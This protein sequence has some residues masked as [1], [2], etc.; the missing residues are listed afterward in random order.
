MEEWRPVSGYE[1]LYEVSS[2]GRVR[3]LPRVWE[4]VSKH[5]TLHKHTSSGRT[6]KPG[7][8]RQGYPSVV[9]GR[10]RTRLVHR[11][12]AEAFLGPCPAGK[13]VRH[14]DGTRTNN[15]ISN[16]AYG[17]RSE[18][19]ADAKLHGTF[20]KGRL[21][22]CKILPSQHEHIRSIYARGGHTYASIGVFFG[23][24]SGAILKI[25]RRK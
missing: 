11:L 24:S 19:I 8:T 23:V 3:S 2:L 21:K 20:Q 4:Q 17:T 16:L 14:L 1:G 5:G 18:N 7:L 6:L 22:M 12:V 13:E 10:R 9:L 15:T 25:V